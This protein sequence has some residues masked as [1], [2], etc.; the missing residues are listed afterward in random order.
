[1][2]K[3][4]YLCLCLLSFNYFN[5]M[6]QDFQVELNGEKMSF[7]KEAAPFIEKGVTFVPVRFLSEKL[8]K[9]ILWEP[10]SKDITIKSPFIT[11]KLRVDNATATVNRKR[12]EL[13][14][15]PQLVDGR[16]YVPLRALSEIFLIDVQ[17]DKP[18]IRLNGEILTDRPA[19][20]G[21]LYPTTF[22]FQKTSLF[23]SL[24]KS[25]F[26]CLKDISHVA[27]LPPAY[28]EEIE[29]S[30]GILQDI[31]FEKEKLYIKE[32]TRIPGL[33]TNSPVYLSSSRGILEKIEPTVL[34]AD[35]QTSFSSYTINQLESASYIVLKH[36]SRE[37]I[38]A[39][40]I[41]EIRKTK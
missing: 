3:L 20:K 28:G 19:E 21:D 33:K 23:N 6:A 30:T 22:S 37:V 36:F 34:A 5:L 24:F 35:E 40:P 12:V 10:S 39:I 1:M 14:T 31:Y 7:E 17:Y 2:R 18:V 32:K 9:I 13:P 11:T 27:I 4:F 26:N 25:S 8:G 41:G 15:S 29:T 38:I 16:V